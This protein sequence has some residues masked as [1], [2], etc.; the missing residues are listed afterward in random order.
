M[1]F[2]LKFK[3]FSLL[4][5][6]FIFCEKKNRVQQN[7]K[8]KENSN[9]ATVIEVDTA[10]EQQ[11]S[12]PQIKPKV[13]PKPNIFSALRRDGR[14]RSNSSV[15]SIR[16]FST[17]SILGERMDSIGRRLSRDITASPPDLGRHFETFGKAA[18]TKSRLDSAENKFDT[19]GGKGANKIDVP[20]KTKVAKRP[21]LNFE[22]YHRDSKSGFELPI[23]KEGLEP[24]IYQEDRSKAVLKAK[25]HRELTA[26]YGPKKSSDSV[27]YDQSVPPPL[28]KKPSRSPKVHIRHKSADGLDSDNTNKSDES[29]SMLK[30]SIRPRIPQM[31]RLSRED[32]LRLSHSSQSEIHEY[33]KNSMEM[34]YQA[35]PP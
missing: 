22:S 7:E 2:I 33:L 23:V 18:S 6:R 1:G 31:S 9:L 16:R 24:P 8:E 29:L 5:F 27:Q 19:F 35:Q 11:K 17:D 26:K 28:P 30:T 25:L 15:L 3:V 34:D 13:S 21:A 12:P 14:S 10:L 4:I 20:Y 32:L